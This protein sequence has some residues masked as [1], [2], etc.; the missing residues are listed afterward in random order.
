LRATLEANGIR[1]EDLSSD[2][3]AQAMEALNGLSSH[4]KKPAPTKSAVGKG[5][6]LAKTAA[7]AGERKTEAERQRKLR[8]QKEIVIELA[9][10]SGKGYPAP[11]NLDTGSGVKTN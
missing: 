3:K 1:F 9:A 5:E 2:E 11:V 7:N 8:T 4:P 6:N 10:P